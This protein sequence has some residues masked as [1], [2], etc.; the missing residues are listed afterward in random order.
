MLPRPERMLAQRDFQRVY[1]RGRVYPSPLVILYVLP[2]EEGSVPWSGPR[3]G[4]VAS[5]KVGKAHDRNHAKRRIREAYRLLAQRQGPPV[6]MV[7]VTRGAAVAAGYSQIRETVGTLL[8]AAGWLKS[9]NP[10]ERPV[11]CVR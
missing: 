8:Q 10:A 6:M 1:R 11:A 5:K 3:V 2:L 7:W 4:F 9:L